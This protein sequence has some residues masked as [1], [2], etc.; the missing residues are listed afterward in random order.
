LSNSG[1]ELDQIETYRLGLR[2]RVSQGEMAGRIGVS[3]D[4]YVNAVVGRMFKGRFLRMKP[5]R[6]HREKFEKFI[7][8]HAAEIRATV[9]AARIAEMREA[10]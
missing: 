9:E 10:G 3:I 1:I 2:P 6:R 5:H 8:R 7:E 4:A